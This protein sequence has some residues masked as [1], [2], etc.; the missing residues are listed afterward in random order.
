M[1]MKCDRCSDDG[2][3]RRVIGIDGKFKPA[4]LCLR[5]FMMWGD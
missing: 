3:E 2:E 5:C 4:N 1:A